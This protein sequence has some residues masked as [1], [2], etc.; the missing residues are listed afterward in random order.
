MIAIGFGWIGS[1]GVVVGRTGAL[2]DGVA[3][4]EDTGITGGVDGGVAGWPLITGL[5]DGVVLIFVPEGF[6]AA[7]V[8]G[9]RGRFGAMVLPLD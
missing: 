2:I 3:A 4:A 9:V 6:V 7:G 1:L 5:R 8:N